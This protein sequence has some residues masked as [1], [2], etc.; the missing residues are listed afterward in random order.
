MKLK[1]RLPDFLLI[2]LLLLMTL[3]LIFTF[4]PR[5]KGPA[6]FGIQ[7]ETFSWRRASL[8]NIDNHRFQDFMET[9]AKQ[10]SGFC[11]W[12][13]RL[14]NELNYR[15][16]HYSN[17]PK[18][19]L[20]KDDC[21][22]EDIYVNEFTG[23]DFSNDSIILSN[24]LKLKTLQQILKNKYNI[25]L[26]WVVEPG[27]V[28]YLPENLPETYKSNCREKTNYDRY[29]FYA[30]RY[31]I[32]CLDINRY[33]RDIRPTTPHPLYS[34]HGIHWS[35]FG[36]WTAADTLQHY[37]ERQTSCKLPDMRETGHVYSAE[38]NDLDFDLEPP[39]NLLF[40]LKHEQV[41]IP[42]M[43]FD[44]VSKD[45]LPAALIIADSYVWSLWNH[46][47][48]AHW[49]RNPQFWYY[50]QTVYPHIWEDAEL[51]DKSRLAET[52][53][54]QDVILLMMTDANL[55]DFG[56]GCLDEMLEIVK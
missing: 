12:G 42:M 4:V 36:M 8:K 10:N 41:Y 15:I 32:S 6:L 38:N 55:R 37:I 22:Y 18:L 29:V 33:F 43:E 44:T 14:Y 39:M 30:D 2:I 49:F 31:R 7:K 46:D 52:L 13:V 3:P 54:Q 53:A 45:S 24:L 19:I 20:G 27:K 28:R 35:T 47:I 26:L 34:R 9:M 11:N 40:P 21:F 51:V 1:Q 50:N 48:L 16:F 25:D 5:S 23:Q 56:W 17:A